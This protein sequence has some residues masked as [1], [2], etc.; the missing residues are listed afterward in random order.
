MCWD[1]STVHSQTDMNAHVNLGSQS[2]ES[3]HSVSVDTCVCVW[4][5]YSPK[6][7]GVSC[8]R[9]SSVSGAINIDVTFYYLYIHVDLAFNSKRFHLYNGNQHY[10]EYIYSCLMAFGVPALRKPVKLRELASTELK[11]TDMHHFLLLTLWFA[12]SC[13]DLNFVLTI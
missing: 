5:G 10:G 8:S 1:F 2:R 7:C 9:G 11:E 6:P 3:I 12:L 13:R 4:I